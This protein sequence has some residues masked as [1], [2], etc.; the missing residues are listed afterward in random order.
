MLYTKTKPFLKNALANNV[1]SH[2]NSRNRKIF[3][4]ASKNHHLINL[5]VEITELDK[6][7]LAKNGTVNFI[8][9]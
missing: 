1:R 3:K 4:A 2:Q 5:T 6:M 8:E 9:T 7:S